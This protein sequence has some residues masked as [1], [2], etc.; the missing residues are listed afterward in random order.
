MEDQSIR[1]NKLRAANLKTE[2][3]RTEVW[4]LEV[5]AVDRILGV[6]D[7]DGRYHERESNL[8]QPS[9]TAHNTHTDTPPFILRVGPNGD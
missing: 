7:V 1:Q 2:R 9:T 4:V 5:R 3:T 8:E 6:L